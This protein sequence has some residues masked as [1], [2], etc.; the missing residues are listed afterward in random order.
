MDGHS[1]AGPGWWVELRGGRSGGGL[2]PAAIPVDC[3]VETLVYVCTD[4]FV[5]GHVVRVV[6]ATLYGSY[7]VDT[8]QADARLRF[9]RSDHL[10]VGADVLC[11][12][13][14]EHRSPGWR[15]SY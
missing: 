12:S 2:E 11:S 9:L 4:H 3:I 8:P 6:C 7:E 5:Y 13:S 14:V 10:S 15:M 1:R